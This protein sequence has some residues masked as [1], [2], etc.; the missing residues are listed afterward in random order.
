MR[1][2]GG[3]WSVI[4][5]IRNNVLVKIRNFLSPSYHL[6]C[7]LAKTPIRQVELKRYQGIKEPLLNVLKYK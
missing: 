1:Y 3:M 7:T 5:I 6:S 2:R 4:K